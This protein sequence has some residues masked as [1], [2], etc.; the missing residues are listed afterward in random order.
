MYYLD[1]DRERGLSRQ[2]PA[3]ICQFILSNSGSGIKPRLRIEPQPGGL[4]KLVAEEWPA[5]TLAVD[6]TDHISRCQ[7]VLVKQIKDNTRL[8][9][10]C[11]IYTDMANLKTMA[12][13][14]QAMLTAVIERGSF[15]GTC[16][17]CEVYFIQT[18]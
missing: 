6:T 9:V 17:L 10:W 5:I 8:Q 11:Q 13:H 15:T 16:S 2:F 14:L 4:Y 3:F 18:S 7:E 12:S 1:Q